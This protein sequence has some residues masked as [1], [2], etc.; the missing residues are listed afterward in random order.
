[1]YYDNKFDKEL[2]NQ[3]MQLVVQCMHS[4]L[5]CSI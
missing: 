1:M 3:L 2:G 5:K 4:W